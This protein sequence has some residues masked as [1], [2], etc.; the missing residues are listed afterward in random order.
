MGGS[1]RGARTLPGMRIVVCLLTGAR[2][3]S[4]MAW[5]V[6]N[7]LDRLLH[8]LELSSYWRSKH[9]ESTGWEHDHFQ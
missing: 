6:L 7:E 3:S 5:V 8:T 4:V 2:R 1:G 9:K